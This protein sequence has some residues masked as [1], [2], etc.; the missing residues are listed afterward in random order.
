M[1][2]DFKCN[3]IGLM[4]NFCLL[5]IIVCI[6]CD[7]PQKIK[8]KGERS[9]LGKLHG[10]GIITYPNG[11]TWEGKFKDGD[12]YTG[13]GVYFFPDSSKYEGEWIDGK[14]NNQGTLTLVDSDRYSGEWKDDKLSGQGIFTSL[15]GGYYAG[16]FKD[17]QFNG[18][19]T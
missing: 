18:L 4:K 9:K 5:F 2:I 19:G 14:R 3:K 6:S 7:V 16:E 12:P 17:D 8:Y 1:S 10:K 11:E 15:G 13:K